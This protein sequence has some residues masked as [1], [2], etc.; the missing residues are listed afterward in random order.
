[1]KKRGYLCEKDFGITVARFNDVDY[2][3]IDIRIVERISNAMNNL[4]RYI[5]DYILNVF[6]IRSYIENDYKYNEFIYI[7]H[8]IASILEDVSTSKSAKNN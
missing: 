4:K 3:N 6:P 5:K 1:M 7:F 2:D 8:S